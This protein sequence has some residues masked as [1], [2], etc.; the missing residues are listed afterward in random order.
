MVP[1]MPFELMV[2]QLAGLALPEPP[3]RPG[4]RHVREPI[5]PAAP[6]EKSQG[7][8]RN[9]AHRNVQKCLVAAG[10]EYFDGRLDTIF[11]HQARPA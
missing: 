8:Q 7:C 5:S 1:L 6:V 9:A 3:D 10:P 11:C 4:R 2:A